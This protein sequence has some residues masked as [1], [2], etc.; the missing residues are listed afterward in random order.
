MRL[1]SEPADIRIIRGVF[2]HWPFR[3]GKG[4]LLR[5]LLPVLR[6]R[7]FVF[8]AASGVLVRA[9]LGDW[10]SIHGLVE[11]YDADF[12]RS[13]SLIR[14]GDTVFD[15]GAN[16]GM[17]SIGAA[18]RAGPAG[19]VHAFEP[20]KSNFARLNE[21]LEL[22]GT[23]SVLARQIAL[24]DRAGAFRFYPSPNKN[25]GVG[26]IV[27]DDWSG[28]HCMVEG[29]TLDEYCE[30]ENVSSVNLLKLD[31]EGAEYH[32]LK[33]AR[34][35]LGSDSPPTIVF[36]VQRVM[37]ED[38]KHSPEELEALLGEFGYSIHAFRGGK[39]Q[40]MTLAGFSGPEDLLALPHNAKIP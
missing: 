3:R 29:T 28:P 34:R 26:R 37:T 36:E 40:P 12:S 33:G 14:T 30:R 23:T 16:V 17:W 19:K 7:D 9:D 15:I 2:H 22:N 20:L 10:I 35:L 13:W 27:V 1:E 25:S 32:V 31:V 8:E 5:A 4:L 38:L 11:G 24:M 21:T 18:R 6:H 39:W